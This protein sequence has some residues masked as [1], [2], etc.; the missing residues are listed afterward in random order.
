VVGMPGLC[1]AGGRLPQNL[2]TSAVVRPGPPVG[3]TKIEAA[4]YKGGIFAYS[5]GGARIPA[6]AIKIKQFH[7]CHR[8]ESNN[9]GNK[10]RI[11][12]SQPRSYFATLFRKIGEEVNASLGPRRGPLPITRVLRVSLI[13]AAISTTTKFF[14]VLLLDGIGLLSPLIASPFGYPPRKLAE[15]SA[16]SRGHKE[17]PAPRFFNG[18]TRSSVSGHGPRIPGT[19]TPIRKV[20][21]VRASPVAGFS[22]AGKKMRRRSWGHSEAAPEFT[23]TKE[24]QRKNRD[25]ARQAPM[26]G[27]HEECAP[28]SKSEGP[29]RRNAPGP[30]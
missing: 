2:L 9:T 3:K 24:P 8:L 11:Q 4:A 21:K 27:G 15:N 22:F 14:G 30:Q 28:F 1:E 13:H 19:S 29:R 12:T 10:R 17:A 5:S 26:V 20:L 25:L 18:P 23:F 7:E 6:S 16:N